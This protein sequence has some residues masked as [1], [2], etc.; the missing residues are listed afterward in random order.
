MKICLNGMT[1]SRRVIRVQVSSES[2]SNVYCIVSEIGFLGFILIAS[3]RKHDLCEQKRVVCNLFS[4][5]SCWL[6]LFI[7]KF[8]CRIVSPSCHIAIDITRIILVMT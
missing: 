1:I 4:N 2:V 7:N 6:C 3:K 5:F 8:Q